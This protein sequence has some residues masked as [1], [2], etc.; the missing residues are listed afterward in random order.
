LLSHLPYVWC[1]CIMDMPPYFLQLCVFWIWIRWW[2]CVFYVIDYIVLII[3]TVGNCFM[4]H[5]SGKSPTHVVDYIYHSS[6]CVVIILSDGLFNYH[7]PR[8]VFIVRFIIFHILHVHRC[9]GVFCCQIYIISYCLYYSLHYCEY[10]PQMMRCILLSD[11]FNF[12]L[13]LLLI[14]L[15]WIYIA[16]AHQCHVNY[17]YSWILFTILTCH[18]RR[19]TFRHWSCQHVKSSVFVVKLF[20]FFFNF[21]MS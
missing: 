9:C 20:I 6:M 19:M 11:I 13:F 1:F 5:A 8:V 18:I 15:L 17:N 3:Y 10:T 2:Y 14:A 21:H 16:S 12:T 7:C 4:V